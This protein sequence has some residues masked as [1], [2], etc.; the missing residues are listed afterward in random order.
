V[1]ADHLAIMADSENKDAAWLW[2]EYLSRPENM[3]TWTYKSK[4]ST[5]LPPR[6]SLLESPELEKEKPVLGG[7]ADMMK[8]GINLTFDNDN[9]GEVDQIVNDKLG[10]A[11]Y[12][13]MTASEALDQAAQE[14]QP[15][16]DRGAN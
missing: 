6:T 1:A 7:F 2:I 3:A 10:R 8:C 9:W 5:L 13:E 11:M 15:L 16:L 14:A 12:G 4:G